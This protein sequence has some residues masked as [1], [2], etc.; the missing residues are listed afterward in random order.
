MSQYTGSF[1]KVAV[2]TGLAM[3]LVGSEISSAATISQDQVFGPLS[4]PS[5]SV[6]LN[7]NLFDPSQ[8]I[9]TSF[10]VDITSKIFDAVGVT[11]NASIT[12]FPNLLSITVS[13]TLSTT[14]TNVNIPGLSSSPF[15]EFNGVGT[16]PLDFSYTADCGTSCAEGWAGD[17]KLT[18]VFDPVNTTPLP[19]ALPLFATGLGALGLLG[20][21]RKRKLAV[22]A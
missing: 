14:P 18:Y 11:I 8:G 7:Y 21:R 1:N 6:I 4:G 17:L 19:A 13:G 10:S 3:L 12:G 16:F 20:W 5:S 2:L 9:L 22:A 15:D